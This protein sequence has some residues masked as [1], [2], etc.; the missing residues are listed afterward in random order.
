MSN[1][2]LV[3][4]GGGRE[5]A[6]GWSIAQ[7]PEV[8]EVLYAPGNAGTGSEE[9]G[10]NV[11][12]DVTKGKTLD[13]RKANFPA[14][15]DLVEK[16][17]VSKIV[18]GPEQPLVDG[19]VDFFYE[20]GFRNIFGPTAAGAKIEADKFFSYD[21]MQKA[22]VPQAHSFGIHNLTDA[23]EA[24]EQLATERGVVLK[25]KGLTAGKGVT[26][27]DSKQAALTGAQKFME[28]YPG[29]ILVAER[30]FGQE[31]SVFGI[32][33]GERVIPIK[34]AVQDHKRLRDNDEGPNTGGM[35]AFCPVPIAGLDVVKYVADNSMTPVVRE[36]K[37][38]GIEYK[39][40]LYA[41]MMMTEQGPKVLEFNCRFGDPE[42]QVLVRKL[43]GGINRAVQAALDGKLTEKDFEYAPGDVCG[44]VLAS[45]G[46]PGDYSA[47]KGSKIV[48]PHQ[49]PS[50][51]KVFHAGT[52][53]KGDDIVVSGG[54][55]LCVTSL[56]EGLAS[57]KYFANQYAGM[58]A[59]IA[60]Q[61][62]PK[63][64]FTY[65]TD[66]AQRALG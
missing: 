39:G 45:Q 48:F 56:Q 15:A 37:R 46:Y 21:V 8:D 18:V 34:F 6:L 58:I 19:V 26:V 57:A 20:K 43:N 5:H 33:D 1:N 13:E 25:A 3:L 55:V 44:V 17:G 53:K 41:G 47:V 51:V 35:G 42:T 38:R 52:A 65:R 32:S 40:V 64:V 49:M 63:K 12:L 59:H 50:H 36:M 60:E 61:V 4:G 10:R 2:V 7:D 62:N 16:E 24:I 27:F 66:I 54:R 11:D 14:L 23:L 30:L 9:K 22:E 31:F 28:T 29:P